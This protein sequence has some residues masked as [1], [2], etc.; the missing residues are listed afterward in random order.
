[1][2]SKKSRSLLKKKKDAIVN[3]SF[4]L[5]SQNIVKK[6]KKQSRVTCYDDNNFSD[7]IYS[8]INVISFQE[9]FSRLKNNYCSDE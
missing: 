1:M 2:N 3:E 8:E 6:F 7:D 9:S 5:H 4:N